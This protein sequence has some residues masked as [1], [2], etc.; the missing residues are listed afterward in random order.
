MAWYLVNPGGASGA[1]EDGL[2]IWTTAAELSTTV[3]GSAS[4]VAVA[5]VSGRTLQVGDL[6]ISS[7]A[8]SLGYYGRVTRCHRRAA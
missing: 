3:G 8:N 6:V 1:G 4:L 5:P 7:H 2:S